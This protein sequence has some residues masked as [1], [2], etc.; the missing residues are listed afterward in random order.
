MCRHQ[1]SCPSHHYLYLECYGSNHWHQQSLRLPVGIDKRLSPVT[2]S[3]ILQGHLLF[4]N[5][6]LFSLS[7]TMAALMISAVLDPELSA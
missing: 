6:R 5:L 3:K 1:K 7:Y 4:S 2:A